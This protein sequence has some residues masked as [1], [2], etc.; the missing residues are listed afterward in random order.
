[1]D[2][3][4]SSHMNKLPEDMLVYEKKFWSEGWELVGG[5]DEVGRGP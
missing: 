4:G 3:K 1:M 2:W 5:V